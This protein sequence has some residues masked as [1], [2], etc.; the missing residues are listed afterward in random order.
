MGKGSLESSP[1][2]PC[3]SWSISARSQLEVRVNEYGE[4]RETHVCGHG[5]WERLSPNFPQPHQTQPEEKQYTF[6]G[7]PCE[8]HHLPEAFSGL[9]LPSMGGT[10]LVLAGPASQWTHLPFPKAIGLRFLY[11]LGSRARL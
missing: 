1:D 6:S 11:P 5:L 4:S 2:G 8:T 9:H 7:R 3:A 10:C